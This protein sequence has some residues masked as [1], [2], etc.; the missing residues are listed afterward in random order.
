MSDSDSECGGCAI[1]N[2]LLDDFFTAAHSWS[3]FFF[4]ILADFAPGQCAT[5]VQH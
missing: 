3:T 2:Y 5:R 4:A 1:I